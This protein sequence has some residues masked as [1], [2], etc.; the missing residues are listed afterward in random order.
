MLKLLGPDGRLVLR[1]G[2]FETGII[3]HLVV[4]PQQWQWAR[5]GTPAGYSPDSMKASCVDADGWP[6]PVGEV[7]EICVRS[8]YKSAGYWRDPQKIASRFFPDPDDA[9]GAI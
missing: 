2:A 6:V 1:Y 5:T 8:R 4:N 3:A 9:D 7:G